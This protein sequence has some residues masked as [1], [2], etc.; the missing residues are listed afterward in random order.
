MTP[1]EAF[2]ALVSRP[3]EA[4]TAGATDARA[5]LSAYLT[6]RGYEVRVQPFTFQPASLNVLPLLG[7]GL[8]WLTLLE[9]PA[10]LTT[11][12]TWLAPFIWLGGLTALGLL[13]WGIGSGVDIPGA[14]RRED[15]NL[16]VTRGT[17]PVRRW[18]VAHVD[19]KAQKHSLAGRLIAVWILLLATLVMTALVAARVIRGTALPGGP[20]AGAAGLVIAAGALA[21]RGKLSGAS[22][23]ARDNATGVLAALVAADTLREDGIG[24][25]FT[26]A[27]EFGLV[28]SRMFVR[29]GVAVE[30]TEVVNL[31]TLTGRGTLYLLAHD[32]PGRDL[33]RRLGQACSGLVPQVEVRRLPLGIL[34]DSLPF[35]RAGAAAVTLSRLDWSDLRRMHTPADTAEGLEPATAESTGAV[36]AN[37]R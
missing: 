33:A 17:R 9:I 24:Y 10:L 29:S 13:A 6:A 31:D 7:A 12:P 32:A 28:G 11:L 5:L 26:G 18:I 25:L 22:P 34:V 23:G 1:R 4:G 36:I 8:G 15:A 35:A 37:L 3:R 30:G 21:A 20:V 16:V 27:E 2:E 14:D 19:S